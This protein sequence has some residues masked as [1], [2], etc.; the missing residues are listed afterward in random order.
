MKKLAV[1]MFCFALSLG[2][3]AAVH[4]QGTFSTDG[5][6]NTYKDPVYRSADH[7]NRGVKAMRKAEKAKEP[8]DRTKLYEKAKEEL[9]KA[10]G[11]DPNFDATLALGQVY[12]ALGKP[13]SALSSC[14]RALALKPK[15]ELAQACVDTAQE[16]R[17]AKKPAPDGSS[18]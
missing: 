16:Q 8:A 10:V 7:Y 4:A 9:S 1:A 18:S 3:A 11:L 17:T 15:N 12:L 13:E 14:V 6:G 2:G 5:M